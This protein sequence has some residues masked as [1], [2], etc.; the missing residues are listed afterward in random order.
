MMV[1]DGIVAHMEEL[2]AVRALGPFPPQ[3]E[4]RRSISASVQDPAVLTYLHFMPE[5]EVS[6]P[7][8]LRAEK[9]KVSCVH[10]HAIG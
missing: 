2:V 9:T 4:K 5:S 1:A 3:D 10:Q 6:R 7:V 8:G